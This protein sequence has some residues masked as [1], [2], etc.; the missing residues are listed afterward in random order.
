[1]HI[2]IITSEFPPDIGGVETYAAEFAQALVQLGYRVSV[3]VHTRHHPIDLPNI[4]IYPV[5]K[6][7]RHLDRSILREYDVDAWHVMN[8]A[9]SWIA[10]ETDKPVVVSI[11][12][13]DFLNPYPL[14]GRPGFSENPKLWRFASLLHPLDHWLGKILTT[15]QM[16]QALPKARALLANSR[17]TE[18]V[19][20][21][22]YP[23]CQ[24][25]TVVAQ[26]GVS[27]LF[28]NS[29]ICKTRNPV[30]HFLTVTRLSEKRKNVDKILLAL[31]EL[32][33]E[34]AFSY[35]IIGDGIY[36]AELESLAEELGL[37]EKVDFS[38]RL[39]LERVIEAMTNA[40]LFIL[41]SSILLDSHEGFGIV[42]LEA[43]ACGTPS[44][45]ARQA[46]A[47]EAIAEG[48]SGFFVEEPTT[49][50]IYSALKNY[51]QD[52]ITFTPENCR[53]FA[54][55]FTW[56]KVVQKALPFYS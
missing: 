33:K 52:Q 27:E 48:V 20:L 9:H 10:L 51:L 23:A 46:G 45:G 43:A 15:C 25:K 37:K 47:V 55:N 14:T 53:A 26:V 16:R 18:Q 2:G 49:E 28:L 4:T 24:G 3:F 8:A 19:F 21:A 38:G 41:P 7:S 5:L 1:M 39:P 34:Y 29:R 40:D 54:E 42:Y 36:K 50:N 12:G 22:R 17:Y 30:P 32:K 13:N 56:D 11:H 35:Q 6:Y 31:G 44:L